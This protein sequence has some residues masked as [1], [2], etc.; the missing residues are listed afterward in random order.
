MNRNWGNQKANPAINVKPRGL[1]KNSKMGDPLDKKPH[2]PTHMKQVVPVYMLTSS[3]TKLEM[4]QDEGSK[5]EGST[6]T[7]FCLTGGDPGTAKHHHWKSD[8]NGETFHLCQ[9][10]IK[11][12][13]TAHW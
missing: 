7:M 4:T 2:V 8:G 1:K 13:C 9:H 5:D 11:T 6:Y 12:Q 3:K 10:Q